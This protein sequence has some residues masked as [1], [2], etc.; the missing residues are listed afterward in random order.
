ML[1]EYKINISSLNN[2]VMNHEL[3]VRSYVHEMKRMMEE[4]P[5]KSDKCINMVN[6]YI[7]TEL[8]DTLRRIKIRMR[9]LNE[10]AKLDHLLFRPSKTSLKRFIASGLYYFSDAYSNH[11]RE[12]EKL[13][14]PTFLNHLAEKWNVTKY[15]DKYTIEEQKDFLFFK[16]LVRVEEIKRNRE[17]IQIEFNKLPLHI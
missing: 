12:I 3:T 8:C 15:M 6:Q 5:M 7:M 2:D 14:A 10:Y 16:A 4:N 13:K 9:C 1:N 17:A 11:Q